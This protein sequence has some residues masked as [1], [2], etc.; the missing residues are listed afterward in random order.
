MTWL[1]VRSHYGNRHVNTHTYNHV[2]DLQTAEYYRIAEY[3]KRSDFKSSSCDA[4]PF[5]HE[6]TNQ[7]TSSVKF[8]PASFTHIHIVTRQKKKQF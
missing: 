3:I 6:Y 8:G 4:C 1:Q 5:S 7:H 2:F